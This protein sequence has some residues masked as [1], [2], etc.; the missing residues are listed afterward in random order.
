MKLFKD[1]LQEYPV[2]ASGDSVESSLSL[3]ACKS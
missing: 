1:I 2:A 3:E